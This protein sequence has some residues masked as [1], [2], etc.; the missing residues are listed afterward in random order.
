MPD[1]HPHGILLLAGSRTHQES[2]ALAFR[3]DPRCRLIAVADEADVPPEREA[4]N[5]QLAGELGIPYIADLETALARDD[6]EIA[7]VCV[8]HER[9][10]RVAIRCAQ[11][12]KHLYLDKP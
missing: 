7:S 10:A 2:Y 5:R 1:P 3:A 12:G 4:L 9:R 6:V 11:A 8:E